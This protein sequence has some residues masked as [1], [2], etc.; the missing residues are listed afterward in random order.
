MFC[1]IFITQLRNCVMLVTPL[2]ADL[3]SKAVRAKIE[4]GNVKAAV[5]ILLSEDTPTVP[6]EEYWRQ[7][8]YVRNNF[9]HS[10]QICRFT[11]RFTSLEFHSE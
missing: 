2:A 1:K 7:L 6:S 11:G 4:N 3:L 9:Q 10:S 8:A 5:R